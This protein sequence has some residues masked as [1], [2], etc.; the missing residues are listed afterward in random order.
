MASTASSRE[1][2]CSFLGWSPALTLYPPNGWDR[3]A[4]F[5]SFVRVVPSLA[6]TSLARRPTG[7][8]E[9]CENGA[10]EGEN[11]PIV[12]PSLISSATIVSR[13]STAAED[14]AEGRF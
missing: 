2:Y 8:T 1:A 7:E 5:R 9:K 12:L 3:C 13:V 6:Q 10:L 11:G 14:L 4:S